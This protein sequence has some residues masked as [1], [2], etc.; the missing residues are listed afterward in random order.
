MVERLWGEYWGLDGLVMRT[1]CGINDAESMRCVMGFFGV[2]GHFCG[3]S[4]GVPW[5]EYCIYLRLVMEGPVESDMLLHGVSDRWSLGL[6]WHCFKN[7]FLTL[8]VLLYLC[9]LC[10]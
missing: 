10:H 3:V 9:S 6:K 5:G 4:D 1:D 7:L 8:L 2:G